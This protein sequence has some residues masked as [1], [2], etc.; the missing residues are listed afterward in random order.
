[1][2]NRQ[3][4]R[5]MDSNWVY[6]TC[7]GGVNYDIGS[8]TIIPFKTMEL[9]LPITLI[10]FRSLET[11]WDGRKRKICQSVFGYQGNIEHKVTVYRQGCRTDVATSGYSPDTQNHILLAYRIGYS[12][13]LSILVEK[14]VKNIPPHLNSQV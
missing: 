13:I 7:M 12:N 8:N 11:F 4:P 1:M 5:G 3:V 2:S 10:S 14:G 6:W 9:P